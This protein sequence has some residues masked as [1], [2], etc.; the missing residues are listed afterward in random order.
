MNGVRVSAQFNQNAQREQSCETYAQHVIGPF[1]STAFSDDAVAPARRPAPRLGKIIG[2]SDSHC[3]A[4]SSSPSWPPPFNHPAQPRPRCDALLSSPT[5]QFTGRLLLPRAP[6]RWCQAAQLR[7][8]AASQAGRFS[9]LHL[10]SS[11]SHDP[12]PRSNVETSS[13]PAL[14]PWHLRLSLSTPFPE[15][16]SILRI[17]SFL[18]GWRRPNL[19]LCGVELGGFLS[20]TR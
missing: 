15:T 9:L 10:C 2:P 20:F 18:R 1:A 13:C 11:S 4:P 17:N 7:P 19:R 5:R 8:G 16:S 3:R 14:R 12:A 6:R